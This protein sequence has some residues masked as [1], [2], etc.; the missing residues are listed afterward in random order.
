MVAHNAEAIFNE[1]QRI[2]DRNGSSTAEEGLE[3]YCR[4]VLTTVERLHFDY[5]TKRDR[6]T[7]QLEEDDKKNLAKGLS[8][9][10]NSSGGVLLW[11]IKGN[12]VPTLTPIAQIETFMAKLLELSGLATEPS[13]LGIDGAWIPSKN[14]PTAGFGAILVPESSLPPHRIV[15]KIK[16]VQHHYYVRTG[17]DFIIAT[18]TMLEDM[19]GRRPRPNLVAKVRGLF[20][21][22]AASRGWEITFDI[23]NEGRGTA[24]EVLIRFED[25]PGMRASHFGPW[26]PMEGGR[27]PITGQTSILLGLKSPSVIYPDMAMVFSNLAISPTSGFRSGQFI[28]LPCTLYC[29]GNPPT[30]LSI[31]GTLGPIKSA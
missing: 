18:H 27:N 21:H 15:L 3:T 16:D 24:K 14:D 2:R 6:R 5:K 4:E 9:F 30:H 1:F 10:A 8:G 19:F 17:S 12:N 13:V 11:G 31:E 20:P 7:P 22:V 29:E 25:Q 28:Q 23:V 26:I